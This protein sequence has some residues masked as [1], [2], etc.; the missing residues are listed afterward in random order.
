MK[1]KDSS[2]QSQP[3]DTFENDKCCSYLRSTFIE[4]NMSMRHNC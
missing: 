2:Q 4:L 3:G 1:I